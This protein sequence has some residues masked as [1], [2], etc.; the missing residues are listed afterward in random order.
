MRPKSPVNEIIV[1]CR[2]P[3]VLMSKKN[4]SGLG[5]PDGGE[6]HVL[7]G[8]TRSIDL[9]LGILPRYTHNSVF[10]DDIEE[11]LRES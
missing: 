2:E 3:P 7:A 4:H 6:G 5:F 8:S 1:V 11:T 10:I 9:S